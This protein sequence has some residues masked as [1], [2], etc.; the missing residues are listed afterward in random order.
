MIIPRR[1]GQEILLH[2]LGST[3]F[4]NLAFESRLECIL[5]HFK[6]FTTSEERYKALINLRTIPPEI[7]VNMRSS[8]TLVRGC[9][10]EMHLLATIQEDLI[11]M[12]LYS[13]SLISLGLAALLFLLFHKLPPKAPFI[14]SIDSLSKDLDLPHLLSLG[15]SNGFVSMLDHLKK[16]IVLL[17]STSRAL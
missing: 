6:K 7:S 4:F 12:E 10:S 15:R 14:H 8:L 13:E 3:E 11:S 1:C 9:Q 5:A 16:Q 17:L 2:Q